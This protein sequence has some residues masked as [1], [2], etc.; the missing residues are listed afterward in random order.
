MPFAGMPFGPFQSFVRGDLL[1]SSRRRCRLLHQK[2]GDWKSP[3]KGRSWEKEVALTCGGGMG[4]GEMDK[5]DALKKASAKGCDCGCGWDP[6]SFKY[7]LKSE[8][9]KSAVLA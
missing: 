3:T 9:H 4:T 8:F 6:P 1:E 5:E 7:E 2:R